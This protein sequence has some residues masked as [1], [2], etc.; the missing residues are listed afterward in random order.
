LGGV[1]A[2]GTPVNPAV[3][4]SNVAPGEVSATS[5]Q[6]VNGAQLYQVQQSAQAYTDQAVSGVKDWAKSYTDSK[7]AQA[8]QEAYEAGAAGGAIGTMA[9]AAT[10]V[11]PTYNRLGNLS[12]AVG[13]YVNRGAVAL[14]WSQSFQNGRV[15]VAVAASFTGNHAYVGG[16]VSIGLGD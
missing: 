15:G 4:L 3:T 14:G 5:T 11:S 10:R 8:R 13:G 9:L 7:F 2:D 12:M 1:S 6:A 16:A